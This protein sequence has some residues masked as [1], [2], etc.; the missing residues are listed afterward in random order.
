MKI[1]ITG[2]GG[3]LGRH[4]RLHLRAQSRFRNGLVP[5]DR[6]LFRD[7]NSRDAALDGADA[8]IHCAGVNR[9][10]A[11]SVEQDNVEIA[12]T[13][14]DSLT[15]S[16]ARPH[17]IYA[18]S[19]HRDSE[20]PYGRGKRA[21][22][23]VLEKWADLT[24]ARYTELVLPH[25]FGEGGRPHYNSAIHTFCH[26]L[27]AG[28]EL[29]I[30]GA[31]QLE[32]IHAHD[33]AIEIGEALDH[34]LSGEL[35]LHGRRMSTATAAGTLVDLHRL[36]RD[37]IVPDLRDPLVLQLFNTLRSYMYPT[38]Y[39]HALELHNDD[40]GTLFEAVKNHNGGQAFLSTTRPGVTRGDHYHFKKVERFLVV[41]GQAVIRIRALLDDRVEE[42]HVDGSAPAYVDI[43]TLHTHN[44][45]N[46]GKD[47]LLTMFWS[48]EI[49][50]PDNPDT[51]AEP[52]LGTQE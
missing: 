11:T 42:F 34:G 45:T 51:F 18:N 7:A 35:R 15:R 31:G 38:H 25:V 28:E 2:A 48:N 21:A 52:V 22:H 26:Q 32:L 4:V 46:T 19:T 24:G 40:R 13:L 44:I 30:N 41:K 36:Y 5:L 3:L 16:G 49:F 14:V 39:P 20:T 33:V 47:E 6:A 10:A 37:G 17:V 8:L 23:A 29:A 1:V 9:G 12:S 27:S 50:D 43:P